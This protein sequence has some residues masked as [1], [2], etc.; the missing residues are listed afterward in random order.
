MGSTQKTEK[1]KEAGVD[2][3]AGDDF[4][5]KIAPLLEQ[6]R[7]P[8]VKG[9]IGHYGSLFSLGNLS[10]KKGFLAASTDGVG[11]KLALTRETQSW[12]ALGQDLVAMCANDILCLGA[13]P[14]FFLDYFVTGKL[15]LDSATQIVGGIARA[16]Q[17]IGC[18]LVGGETAEMPDLYS[19]DGFDLAGFIVGWVSEDRLIDGTKVT[20]GDTVIGLASSGFH[21]NG[22]SLL[23]KI[24]SDHKLNL[25]EPLETSG[26]PLGSILSRPTQLYGPI[27]DG[28]LEKH[29]IH[30]LAH[31]TGG[32]LI[33]NLPR[34][35]PNSCQVQL[36]RTR[37]KHP[38]FFGQIQELGDISD[39]EMLK[40]FNDGIGMVLI[41]P[42]HEVKPILTQLESFQVEAWSIGEVVERSRAMQAV[43]IS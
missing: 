36:E 27:L 42:P 15:E 18:A 28:I 14:L 29:E 23:R 25:Q 32:G 3:A 8:E 24:I 20:I 31:I 12:S 17:Q 34:I 38:P 26:E 35:L 21:A 30:G 41:I 5:R 22:Y 1:Y 13:K 19:P 37:W 10:S 7:R 40:V 11:T 16:C 6:T 4:V 9:G 43:E 39:E 33:G 2:S